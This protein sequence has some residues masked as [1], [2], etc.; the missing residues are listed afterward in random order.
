[1]MM[2][3][4]GYVYIRSLIPRLSPPA[5]EF[6]NV[7]IWP[8]TSHSHKTSKNQ[9][10]DGTAYSVPG[11]VYVVLNVSPAPAFTNVIIW[12]L[13]SYSHKLMVLLRYTCI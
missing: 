5:P 13:T 11:T 10:A 8:L 2:I 12:P 3:F 7:I 1:M 9:V 4:R 6:T